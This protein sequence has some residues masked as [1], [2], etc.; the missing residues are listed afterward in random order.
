MSVNT[1]SRRNLLHTSGACGLAALP[2]NAAGLKDR[3]RITKVELFKVV[4][5]MQDDIINSPEFG[6]D[7]LTEFPGIPKFIV[8]VRTDSGISG[9]GETS[10]GLEERLVRRNAAALEGKNIFDLNLARLDL[11][12]GSGYEGFEMAIYD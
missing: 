8:K 12:D 2:S 5:P 9:V 6:P 1:F 4:V 3:L 7:A 10:R 11:P